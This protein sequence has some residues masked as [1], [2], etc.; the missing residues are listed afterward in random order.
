[1]MG[2]YWSYN[3]ASN[4]WTWRG[5]EG[6]A[7]VEPVV[8]SVGQ[9]GRIGAREGMLFWS[10]SSNVKWAFGGYTYLLAVKSFFGDLWKLGILYMKN[11]KKYSKCSYFM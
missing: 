9:H 10:G 5:G 2:D 3:V 4:A 1:M 11:A 6:T 8:P 7:N